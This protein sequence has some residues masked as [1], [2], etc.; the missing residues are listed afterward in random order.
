MIL[1]FIHWF[2]YIQKHAPLKLATKRLAHEHEK[3]LKEAKK[4]NIHLNCSNRMPSTNLIFLLALIQA[5][6]SYSHW[7][8]EEKSGFWFLDGCCIKCDHTIFIK[9]VTLSI[10]TR[11]FLLLSLVEST[12]MTKRNS[13][14]ITSYVFLSY[15]G[16]CKVFNLNQ[17]KFTNP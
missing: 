16:T 5:F 2:T 15:R 10:F 12:V 9:Y 14:F 8:F 17:R 4:I 13:D 1:I 6:I 7:K 11:I 3:N